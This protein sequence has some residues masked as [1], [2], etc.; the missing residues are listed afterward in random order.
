MKRRSGTAR[1]LTIILSVC[2]VFTMCP[3]IADGWNNSGHAEA[4]SKGTA[5]RVVEIAKSCKEK[6]KKKTKSALKKYG[7]LYSEGYK[8]P[9]CMWFVSNCGK[10][11]GIENS[12]TGIIRQLACYRDR[13]KKWGDY[14]KSTAYG[15]K[16]YTPVAGDLIF[17][18]W[19]HNEKVCDHV[20]IVRFTDKEGVHTV[21]GNTNG[22]YVGYHT[23]SLSAKFIIGFVHPDYKSS[24]TTSSPSSS[25]SHKFQYNLNGG[26]G[27]FKPQTVQDGGTLKIP[28]AKP[29]KP[30]CTFTGW[31]VV[32]DDKKW[33]VAGKGWLD[34][35]TVKS[36]NYT[37]KK[38]S[39]GDSLVIG[40]SWTT[41]RPN[42]NY[43]FWAQWQN[44]SIK[45]QFN[46]NSGTGSIPDRTV[47]ITSGATKVDCRNLGLQKTGYALDGW[48]VQ[49]K[50]GGSSYWIVANGSGWT[51]KKDAAAAE[52]KLLR[53][54][55]SLT[56]PSGSVGNGDTIVFWA[57]WKAVGQ[58]SQ[59]IPNGIYHI[60]SALDPGFGL[61]V[62]GGYA[63][64]GTNVQLYKNATDKTQ[65]FAVKYVGSGYYSIISTISAK[66]LDVYDAGQRNGTNVHVYKQNNT[67]AQRWIIKD[68]G[69]GTFSI[70]SK[71][72]G[73]CVDVAGSRAVNR[74]NIQMYQEDVNSAAQRWRFVSADMQGSQTVP[75]GVYHITSALNA[76]FGL[77]VYNGSPESRTNV[78]LY[79][80]INDRTQT[81]EVSY[82]GSGYYSIISTIGGKSLDVYD[83]GNYNGVNVWVYDPNYR[84]AQQWIIKDRGDGTYSIFSRCN[85]LCL[86]VK[87][88]KAVNG[89]NIQMYKEDQSSLAQRWKF[90]PAN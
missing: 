22:G 54:T 66:S 18:S 80:N 85:E 13:Y 28:T 55:D 51:W 29:T 46:N 36:K 49:K 33:Y 70:I 19:D 15:G 31:C 12:P 6:K 47:A 65:T 2:M 83:A 3:F 69:D 89:A 8:G 21:E 82:M 57:S 30:G 5:A 86:D 63:E 50:S 78:Q 73:L 38:Y 40:D 72:N 52:R 42:A 48:K 41:G 25:Y 23:Y 79:R 1:I 81:F 17:Y 62:Y 56:F 90:I 84:E 87:G 77:D 35:D 45:V 20:G 7:N 71:C 14:H 24:T 68:R 37:F 32:R 67:D 58:G 60:T 4:A 27:T 59:T 76:E 44:A 16:K 75:D 61:D 43:T 64:S 39:P 26:S 88:S 11:A 34:Y 9:W 53:F 74:A 10:L